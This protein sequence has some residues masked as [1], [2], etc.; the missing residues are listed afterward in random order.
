MKI[1]ES[2]YT[3]YDL[4][5][6]ETIENFTKLLRKYIQTNAINIH[7]FGERTI[8]PLKLKYSNKEN[9]V[10]K[11]IQIRAKEIFEVLQKKDFEIA[12]SEENYN[13]QFLDAILNELNLDRKTGNFFKQNIP[14]DFTLASCNLLEVSLSFINFFLDKKKVLAQHP[15]FQSLMKLFHIRKGIDFEELISDAESYIKLSELFFFYYVDIEELSYK[16]AKHEFYQFLFEDSKKIQLSLEETLRIFHYEYFHFPVDYFPGTVNNNLFTGVTNFLNDIFTGNLPNSYSNIRRQYE[17]A[18]PSLILNGQVFLSFSFVLLA[19]VQDKINKYGQPNSLV[20]TPDLDEDIDLTDFI[21]DVIESMILVRLEI[22]STHFDSILKSFRGIHENSTIFPDD[23]AL[24]KYLIKYFKDLEKDEERK[25]LTFQGLKLPYKLNEKVKNCI[26]LI[27]QEKLD[28][29]NGVLH[30]KLILPQAYENKIA[31]SNV[32]ELKEVKSD[33]PQVNYPFFSK[34]K[35]KWPVDKIKILEKS[36]SYLYKKTNKNGEKFMEEA[37]VKNMLRANYSCYEEPFEPK[38]FKFNGSKI[39]CR[40]FV[41]QIYNVLDARG[42]GNN[43]LRFA[44][45]LV[46]NIDLFYKDEWIEKDLDTLKR[47]IKNKA[48]GDDDYIEFDENGIIK[49]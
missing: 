42:E 45:F 36:H 20:F 18:T 15:E 31:S 12:D 7:W 37:E 27:I 40:F 4:E 26:L 23:K 16:L 2:F 35:I 49:N 25:L 3:K 48:P 28:L 13:R 19:I 44:Q 14:E 33:Y 5:I 11:L 6:R 38:V 39:A 34:K 29:K 43:L 17:E 9:P 10:E 41:H 30:E 47:N 32:E 46:Q 1:W 8:Q 22:L 21:V 24:I